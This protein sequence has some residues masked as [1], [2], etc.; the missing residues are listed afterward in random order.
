MKV[1]K[2]IQNSMEG[3]MK[4]IKVLG[5]DLAKNV[6]Q[7]HGADEHGRKV[8]SKRLGREELIEF[9]SNSQPC[10]V[11]IEACGSAHYWAR[12]FSAQGHTVKMMAPQ[13]VKP[14]VMSNKNDKN[15]AKGIAEAVTRPGMKFVPI[16]TMSQQDILLLHRARELSVKNRTAQ[17]NQIRGLLSEYGI[18]VSKGLSVIRKLPEVL[19]LNQEKLTVRAKRVFEML[20]DQFKAYDKQVDNYDKEIEEHVLS[21]ALCKEILKIPGLGI[22]STSAIVAT[23]G[24]AKGFKNGREVAAWLGLVPKQHSSGNKIRL[25]SISKRGDRYA[26]C[27]LIHGARCVLKYVDNKTDRLSLWAFDKKMKMPFNKV[28]VALANKN[29]RIIWSIMATGEAYRQPD[30]LAV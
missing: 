22:I 6:F 17:G 25:G 30:N 24:D 4:D 18:V 14:Y 28:A 19:E 11:G 3:P 12:L 10:I 16:K 9:M 2:V 15:D 26:R 7:V 5:V 21:D 20:H 1:V 29:A 8:L 13:F 23:I 27:L